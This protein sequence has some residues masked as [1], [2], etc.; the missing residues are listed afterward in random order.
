MLK[1]L[2]ALLSLALVPALGAPF[3]AAIAQEPAA[4]VNVIAGAP[5]YDPA[6]ELVGP[7]ESVSGGNAVIGLDGG[8]IALPVTSFGKGEKGLLISVSRAELVAARD[9]AASAQANAVEAAVQ[10]GAEVRGVN[11]AT[12]LATVKQVDADGVIVSTPAGDV[13]LP[14]SAFFL[15]PSGLA[16]SFSPAQFADALKQAAEGRAKVDAAV[17][18][19]LKPGVTVYS[20]KGSQILGTVKSV[21]RET[22]TLATDQGDVPVA[23]S[24]FIMSP[25]GLAAAYAAE[26]FADAVAATS[27]DGATASDKR[28]KSAQ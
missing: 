15:S 13:K 17:A 9:K 24:A 10:P 21:D 14:R 22:V 8:P 3:G 19:A 25:K 5:V 18:S 28:Q 1:R 4:N 16:M 7:V 20:A 12:V 2:G 6:G 27:E 26:Q 23:R 11:G